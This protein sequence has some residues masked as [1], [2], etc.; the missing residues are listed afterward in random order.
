MKSRL[1]MRMQ[2]MEQEV[3]QLLLAVFCQKKLI[4][5]GK[6]T[7]IATYFPFVSTKEITFVDSIG[8]S[9]GKAAN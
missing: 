3:C 7:I 4:S 2:G 1:L 6:T 8:L 5:S 9:S